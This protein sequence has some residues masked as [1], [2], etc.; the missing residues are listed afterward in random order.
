MKW[1]RFLTAQAAQA[2]AAFILAS[3]TFKAGERL[4]IFK[5]AGK[6]SRFDWSYPDDPRLADRGIKIVCDVARG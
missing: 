5:T 1:A 6:P 4:V 2:D 3:S